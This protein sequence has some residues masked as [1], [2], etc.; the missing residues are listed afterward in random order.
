[1]R[2]LISTF[3][4]LLICSIQTLAQSTWGEDGEIEDAEIL[5]EKDRKIEL[6]P[7]LRNFEKV[8]PPPVQPVKT[9]LEYD[10]KPFKVNFSDFDPRIR[11]LTIKDETIPKLY[12]N[13]LKGGIANY[14]TP[15][16]EGY[17]NNKRNKDYSYGARFRHLSSLTGPVDGRN[18]G[19][20]DNL[21]G[22][23]GKYFGDHVNISSELS[24]ER[25][26]RHFYGYQPGLEVKRDT[27]R[28]VYGFFNANV[29]FENAKDG[30]SG[31]KVKTGFDRVQDN[32]GVG[33][34]M[35]GIDIDA[36]H[37]LSDLLKVSIAGDLFLS[38]YSDSLSSINR[39]LLRLKPAFN[40]KFSNL[41]V[42]AGFNIAYEN[43]TIASGNELH[44]YPVVRADYKIND[45]F[46]A[47]AGID[48]DM[49]RVTLLDMA[50]ENPFI[51]PGVP[52]LHANKTF[53]LYGGLTGILMKRLSYKTGFSIA[54]YRNMGFFAN[55]AQDS[56]R[57]DVLYETGRTGVLNIFAEGGFSANDNVRTTLRADYYGYRVSTLEQA[58]H[59]PRYKVNMVNT[60]NLYKKIYFNTDLF[61]LGGI[62]G[63][64]LASGEV[65]TLKNIV[66]LNL[67]ADYLFSDRAST[68]I[69]FNNMLS[70]RYET[71]LNYPSRGL[72]VMLG[73]TYSF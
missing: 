19:T 66:D 61:M 28:Q 32:Y 21:I 33:E 27:I 11:V 57:F 52:L 14:G 22:L 64:N 40:I 43:D 72:M 71:F 45:E 31:Y 59:R 39:N 67:K 44:Y 62:Q 46:A 69:S 35:F 73:F 18:S 54:N 8:S 10:F 53:E 65:R 3:A 20:S 48:G 2:Y 6:P 7:A 4:V 12:G 49:E 51:N 37:N 29:A 30:D 47:F 68:F 25:M 16:L 34:N 42:R 36:H 41:E 5:I 38:K 58:W 23:N 60:F 50:R 63:L 1:M 24:Y 70:R 17:F 15:Y 56:T 55:S 13:Y 9:N 26:M